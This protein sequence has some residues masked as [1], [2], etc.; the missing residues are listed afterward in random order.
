MKLRMLAGFLLAW[1][2]AVPLA[3]AAV[4]AGVA[5]ERFE[6]PRGVPLAGYSRRHGKPS[7]GMHDPVGVRALALSDEDTAA[8]LV[9]A[10]L[11]IIDE[12]LFDAANAGLRKAGLP[13]DLILV[14]SA[15]H[16]HSGPGAYGRQFFEKISMGHYD[17]AVFDALVEAIVR[18][19]VRAWEQRVPVRAASGAS[20]AEGLVHNRVDDAGPVDASVTVTGLYPGDARSPLALVVSFAAHPTTL[21]A[22]NMELSGDY[23]GVLM[24]ELERRFP[25]A[26]ALF[27]A[28]SAGDQAPHKDGE[29]F[30]RAERLG[31]ALAER[32]ASIVERLQPQPLEGLRARQARMKLPPA[33][34]RL[35]PVALPRWMGRRLVDDD[36]TLSLVLVGPTVFMGVPCDLTTRSLGARLKAAARERGL[37]PHIVGFASDYI[38]Y[39]IP[40]ALYESREYESALAFNGPRAGE[41]VIEKLIEMLQ[42]QMMDDQ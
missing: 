38:G 41:L 28:G 14:L 5:S 24:R 4:Q 34:V 33:H 13:A 39:C 20:S 29:G 6:L 31:A 19:G 32:A 35:G 21:G 15:T 11:L 3:E 42:S 12:P 25:S 40:E 10:D 17:A 36:A 37:V 27:F 22:S 1:M 8:M 30:E 18:G 26:T 7:R 23:P 2:L 9:S 16:T